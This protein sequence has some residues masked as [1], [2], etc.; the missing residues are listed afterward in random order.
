MGLNL[1]LS[2]YD[3]NGET[4][5]EFPASEWDDSDDGECAEDDG[6]RRQEPSDDVGGGVDK[7]R[8]GDAETNRQTRQGRCQQRLHE[9]CG[10]SSI[11]DCCDNSFRTFVLVIRV[12]TSRLGQLN[13]F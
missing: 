1:I 2:T 5:P 4:D 10:H 12:R 7:D 3:R 9:Q 8:Q 13:V 11:N 6:T